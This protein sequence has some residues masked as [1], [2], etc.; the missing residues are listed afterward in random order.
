MH[1]YL[2]LAKNG[3]TTDEGTRV[4]VAVLTDII[5]KAVSQVR[6]QST[7]LKIPKLSEVS[8][9]EVSFGAQAEL[10]KNAEKYCFVLL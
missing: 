3:L 9:A 4:D 6:K 2:Y 8:T 5:K 10:F 7:C 1:Y